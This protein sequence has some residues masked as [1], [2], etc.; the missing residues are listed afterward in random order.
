VTVRTDEWLTGAAR[1]CAD[2]EPLLGA[3]RGELGEPGAVDGPTT[4]VVAGVRVVANPRVSQAWATSAFLL[5]GAPDEPTLAQVVRWLAGHAGGDY[6][7]VTRRAHAVDPRWASAGL[8]TWEVQPV[9]AAPVHEAAQ[10]SYPEPGHARLRLTRRPEEFWQAYDCWIGDHDAAAILPTPAFRRPD[11]GFLVAEVDGTPMGSA[12][13]RW[14][15]GTGYL[16]GIGVRP[17][18][19]GSGIGGAL[20]A[21]ATALAVGGPDGDGRDATGRDIDLVW[22]HASTEGAPMYARLGFAEVDRHV[23]LARPAPDS[24]EALPVGRQRGRRSADPDFPVGVGGQVVLDRTVARAQHPQPPDAAV[25]LGH[26]RLLLHEVQP[27]VI[28]Y[29]QPV[30]HA[31]PIGESVGLDRLDPLD[32]VVVVE[33][34]PDGADDVVDPGCLPDPARRHPSEVELGVQE[35]A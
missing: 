8:A 11:W 4:S 31:L 5:D 9:F 29:Q 20:T 16:G 23:I 32:L 26:V 12:I 21:R 18:H 7:V 33:P 14:V 6:S 2:A 13:I 3:Q 30:S 35:V 17:D 24:D 15:D 25:A 1:R 10:L 27:V 34:G 28:A 19:Q 22:M